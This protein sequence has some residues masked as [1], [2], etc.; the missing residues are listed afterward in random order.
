MR[1]Y[2]SATRIQIYSPVSKNTA[3]SIKLAQIFWLVLTC[4]LFWFQVE[5]VRLIA[6]G[7]APRITQP[8][9]GATYECIQ[10]KDNSKVIHRFLG[11]VEVT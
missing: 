8:E 9:E 1:A 7:K 5:A 6:E 11:D 4:I 3:M 10:K 2:I